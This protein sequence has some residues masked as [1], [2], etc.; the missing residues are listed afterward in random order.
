MIAAERTLLVLLAAGR[1]VR[2]GAEDKL[3]AE[4]RGRPLA[5]HAVA[6]LEEIDFLGRVAIVSTTRVD[7]ARAGYAIV[8][9]PAPEVGMSGSLRLGVA[10]A[11]ECGA[12]AM[13]V[14]LADMPHIS[15]R[16]IR[17]L[18]ATA[19]RADDAIAS[20]DGTRL[21][22]PALFAAGHFADL[23]RLSGDTGARALLSTAR[24]VAAD[25]AELIDIDTPADLEALRAGA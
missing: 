9:N 21:M 4:Y 24:A 20:T 19:D 14:A 13:L 15:A 6:A 5:L 11:R 18:L 17:R 7:F 10:A 23:A 3:A 2:F 1:S 12:A 16:H 22:P 8:A 25:P